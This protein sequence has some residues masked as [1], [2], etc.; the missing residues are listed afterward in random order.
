MEVADAIFILLSLIAIF[1]VI[2]EGRIGFNG[3]GPVAALETLKE[4]FTISP[5]TQWG[6]KYKS[7]MKKLGASG[8]HRFKMRGVIPTIKDQQKA[9]R[10]YDKLKDILI[11]T[12][13]N[14]RGA[15][16]S[17]CCG[18]GGWEQVVAPLPDVTT[19]LSFTLGRGP[20]H[21]GHE[22]FS[23]R[24]FPGKHKVKLTYAD[25]RN[26]PALEHDTLLFDGGESN[27]DP[28]KEATRFNDLFANCV[29]K[30]ITSKTQC[31]VLKVLT[32][33]HP[34]TVTM[35]KNIQ[36]ITGQGFFVRS[37]HSR[38]SSLELYFVSGP[39]SNVE[40]DCRSLLLEACERGIIGK[41]YLPKHYETGYEFYRE[42]IAD[43]LE[44]LRPL[45][46]E[47][48]IRQLGSP[49]L[50][51]RRHFAHWESKGVYPWGTRGSSSN[52]YNP[53]MYYLF[54]SLINLIPGCSNWSLTDTTPKG[55]M[56]VFNRKVDTAPTENH[57]HVERGHQ[58][59]LG[60]SD[61][62]QQMGFKYREWSWEEVIMG[63]NKQGAAGRVDVG[64]KTVGDFLRD[65]T[66]ISQVSK[67]RKTL[68]EDKPTHGIF[69]TIGKREKKKSTGLMGSRMVAFLPI[70][71]RMLELRVFGCLQTLVK[72][73]MNRLA[74]GGLSILDLGT[75]LHQIWKGYATSSDIA[76]F[77]T[78]V[79]LRDLTEECSFLRRLGMGVLGEKM[80]RLYAFPHILIPYVGVGDYVR[81]ELLA[82]RGQRMSGTHP[83]YNMNTMQRIAKALVH[84]STAQKISEREVRKWTH[85]V[86]RGEG[87][88]K[89]FGM[90]VS[91][92]DEIFTGEEKITNA[93]AKHARVLDELGYPRKDI[94]L[95]S[96]S[97]VVYKLEDVDFCS[98]HYEPITYYDEKQDRKIVKWM[99][100]R[101]VSE[102]LGKACIMTAGIIQQS[103]GGRAGELAWAGAQ[104]INLLVCYHHIRTIRMIAWILRAVVPVELEL[105]AAGGH[106]R[107]TPWIG[108]GDLLEI[109]NRVHFGESAAYPVPGFEV[110]TLKH[111]GY[112][113]PK[114]ELHYDPDFHKKARVYWR[115]RV[116]ELTAQCIAVLGTGGDIEQ[117]T[118]WREF[119]RLVD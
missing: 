61:H 115:Q 99:P 24:P 101:D 84:L 11:Q 34:R 95:E 106:F 10:G 48:S 78:R 77:D 114:K 14:V 40:R 81:S 117:L 43:E 92:D 6:E 39:V 104:A 50:A 13:I 20:G 98:H 1:V 96:P 91:G 94:A 66:W 45:D 5:L 49:V 97:T 73:H 102:I 57:P 64:Y 29:M 118:N 80:Y 105:T 75:R 26:L 107:P 67:V 42:P 47:S 87:D 71:M 4:Q 54:S 68:M 7:T 109:I 60:L 63:A 15:I 44:L 119:T 90:A 3:Y 36:E 12:R 33:W 110:R 58:V 30:Q 9:S 35:L 18:R 27:N 116:Y 72:P 65:P 82:G 2:F 22:S 38:I 113:P 41:K 51:A 53:V 62:F 111:L 32:P 70:P 31:F 112:M 8:F 69:N 103:D 74:V 83:T 16:L 28:E 86:M 59:W 23:E 17:L 85:Q 52:R 88:G 37:I 89:K 100:T 79:S 46:M 55:F 19:V 25:A 76:G 93:Y 21:E 108:N 56:G